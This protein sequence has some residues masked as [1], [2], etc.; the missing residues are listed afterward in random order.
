MNKDPLQVTPALHTPAE[1]PVGVGG[2][3]RQLMREVPELFSKELAL[4]KAELQH[5]LT[6]LKAGTAAVAAGA[7][8]LLAGFIIL[9]LAAVYGLSMFVEPWLAAVIVGGVTVVIGMIMLQSGKKQFDPAQLTPD[10]TLH[11]MQ[12]DKDALKRKLP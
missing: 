9:L 7:I 4:A 10:R 5:N 2:L 8:V 3:L 11:A 12:Q 6:A 1:D